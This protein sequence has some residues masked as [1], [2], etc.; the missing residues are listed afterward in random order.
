[1]NTWD[2]RFQTAEYVYGEQPNAFIKDYAHHLEG[3]S[4]IAAYAEGEGRNAV[5]LASKGYDVTAYDY[6]KSGLQKTEHLAK[7][8]LVS[9][10]T[11]LADLLQDKLPVNMYDAAIMVFGHFP[12]EQQWAVF[13]KIID[14]VK[15]GGCIMMELYSIYQLPYG[16]GGPQQINLLYNPL[17]VLQWCQ[18]HKILHFFTGEQIRYEGMLHTGLAHTIQLIIQK[19]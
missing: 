5:Y 17:E 8:H 13:Q 6:A 18:A 2:Q 9:V 1:M 10:H 12:M 16:S 11:V 7:K 19:S 4:S 14:S 3:Y 15:P